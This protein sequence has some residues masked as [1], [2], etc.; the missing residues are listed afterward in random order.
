MWTTPITFFVIITYDII[1]KFFINPFLKYL[2]IFFKFKRKAKFLIEKNFKNNFFEITLLINKS[3]DK[4]IYL[5][6]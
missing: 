1:R 3:Y 6:L 2:K 5:K 4:L